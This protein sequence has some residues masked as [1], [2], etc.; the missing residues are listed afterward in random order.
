MNT[1]LK[2]M[3]SLKRFLSIANQLKD[4]CDDGSEQTVREHWY[5]LGVDED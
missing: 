5:E 2:V 1:C 4:G 3:V